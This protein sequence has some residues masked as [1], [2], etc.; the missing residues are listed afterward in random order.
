[1]FVHSPILLPNETTNN[2]AC[3][4]VLFVCV[5]LIPSSIRCRACRRPNT[6]HTSRRTQH[7]QHTLRRNSTHS[8]HITKKSTQSA[9]KMPTTPTP[10][11]PTSAPAESSGVDPSLWRA[12]LRKTGSSSAVPSESAT[13]KAEDRLARSASSSW[14]HSDKSSEVRLLDVE[15]F[16]N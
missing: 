7:T 5:L 13:T 4:L 11:T 16:V 12:G 9:L 10:P 14:V 3:S 15:G 2:N 1:M 6:Q 8:T